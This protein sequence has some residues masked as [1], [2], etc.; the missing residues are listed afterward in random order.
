MTRRRMIVIAGVAAVVGIV[1]TLWAAVIARR[2]VPES[3]SGAATSTASTSTAAAGRKIKARLYYVS[4]DGT[5]LTGVDREVSYAD[6]AAAQAQ[7]IV[8]AQLSPVTAP[9]VSPIPPSTTLRALYLDPKG[10]AFVDLSKEASTGHTG[11]S[12]DELLTVYSIVNALTANLPAITAV[13]VLVDGKQVDTLAGHIDLRRP[14][15]KNLAIIEPE[16]SAPR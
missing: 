2:R 7:Q 1:V 10:V 14:L 15:Q 16:A 4:M 5:K 6:G 11:G 8:S 12:Q 9:F 3:P 13:Q